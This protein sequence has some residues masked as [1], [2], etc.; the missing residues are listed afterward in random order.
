MPKK[1]ANLGVYSVD[2]MMGPVLLSLR[3][4]AVGR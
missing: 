3:C 4:S 2:D 1:G